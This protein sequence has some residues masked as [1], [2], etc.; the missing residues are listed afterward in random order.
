MYPPS[1]E[2]TLIISTNFLGPRFPYTS[3]GDRTVKLKL[4][5]C[6]LKPVVL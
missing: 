1:N 5:V 2:D 3:S 6:S 4:M